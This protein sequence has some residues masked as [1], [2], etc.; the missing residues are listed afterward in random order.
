MAS[1][2][3]LPASNA[4]DLKI[5]P[6]LRDLIP[7]LTDGEYA[8][9]K[10]SIEKDGCRE[11]LTI[12]KGQNIILDGHN[13][14][15]ICRDLQVPFNTIE[16]ELPDINAAKI[17]MIKNQKG[18]RNLAE[19]QWAML[20]VKLEALYA[21]EAKGRMGSR[22]DLGLNLGQ[23]E[24]GRSAEKAAKDMG[25]SHQTVSFA[26]QVSNRGI[27]DLVKLVESGYASVSSAARATSLPAKTQAKIVER[28][29]TQIKEG[30]RPN[31][32]SIIREIAPKVTKDS[33]DDVL[34][35]SRN[36]LNACLEQLES[37]ET[38]QRSENLVEM[39]AMSERLTARLKEIEEISLD[40]EL[41]SK[42]SC[43]I[44]LRVCV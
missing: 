39:Q 36:G 2:S 34:E 17:W 4:P 9:L 27:P 40:P 43:V 20:A 31:I 22:T 37:L 1:E 24:F 8:S 35:R 12:W 42:E 38:T 23:G 26:K 21:E 11:P 41:K 30:A 19:S 5:D 18:R 32:A 10:E 44:E 28:A 29:Q 6:E 33:P 14:Y 13:R 15:E 3:S 25:V 7:P 16:I